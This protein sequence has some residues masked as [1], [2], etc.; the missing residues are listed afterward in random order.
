MVISAYFLIPAL[1]AFS[2]AGPPP[3]VPPSAPT[4]P[5][6]VATPEVK[7]AP[8]VVPQPVGTTAEVAVPTK[9]VKIVTPTPVT[10]KMVT[11]GG[12]YR[13]RTG[14]FSNKESAIALVSKLKGEG[15]SAVVVS[16]SGL[17]RVQCGAFK[18]PKG[19]DDL[20]KKLRTKGCTVDIIVSD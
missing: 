6:T 9:E 14:I 1:P 2:L 16:Q 10:N 12:L 8:A 18:N 19:A 4:Y 3:P 15:F 17:W 5:A 20:A 13:V 11:K 7:A